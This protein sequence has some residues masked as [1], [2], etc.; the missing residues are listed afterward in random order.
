M[1][2]AQKTKKVSKKRK[3]MNDEQRHA[4]AVENFNKKALEFIN[5]KNLLFWDAMQ[6]FGMGLHC[7]R[8][9]KNY[10]GPRNQ[11]MLAMEASLNGYKSRQWLTYRYISELGGQVRKGEYSTEV[12]NIFLAPRKCH[13]GDEGCGCNYIVVTVPQYDGSVKRE[14]HIVDSDGKVVKVKRTGSTPVFNLDQADWEN[15]PKGKPQ[16]PTLDIDATVTANEAADSIIAQYIA[17][18]G[19]KV[20]EVPLSEA[21]NWTK[22]NDQINLPLKAQWTSEGAYYSVMFHEMA[23]STAIR[24]DKR[25][26]RNVS[27]YHFSDNVRGPEEMAA[28]LTSAYLKAF[29]GVQG[30][31]L[32]EN[33][34]A[35]VQSWAAA[36]NN[37]P[38]LIAASMDMADRISRYILSCAEECKLR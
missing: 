2:T 1:T 21:P 27:G 14:R 3:G 32:E 30:D 15:A 23:H 6:D 7:G 13:H 8:D 9:G 38:T 26:K 4:R 35:Y 29:T 16:D 36:I 31:Q 22:H 5:N 10:K 28:E 11:M 20:V 18:T 12:F 25:V 17:T 34:I 24:E 19:V 37:N 33:S